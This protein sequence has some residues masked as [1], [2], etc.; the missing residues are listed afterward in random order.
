MPEI[1]L[2]SR[3]ENSIFATFAVDWRLLASLLAICKA[4]CQSSTL[5]Y[6]RYDRSP[7]E[8]GSQ[9]NGDRQRVG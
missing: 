5:V 8:S 6:D 4:L 3:L 2:N 9:V 7:V 1:Q